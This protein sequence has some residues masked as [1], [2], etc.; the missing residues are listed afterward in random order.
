MQINLLCAVSKCVARDRGAQWNNGSEINRLCTIFSII[1][2]VWIFASF[3]VFWGGAPSVIMENFKKPRMP[4]T[5]QP[6]HFLLCAVGKCVAR[7]RGA[8]W[9]NGFEINL[10]CVVSKCVA[11]ARGAQ[12]NN[13][14][15]INRLCTIFK[16]NCCSLD[17]RVFHGFLPRSSVCNDGEF[18]KT[19]SAK[20]ATIRAF[21][22]WRSW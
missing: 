20:N 19:A 9:N 7:A 1:A 6:E 4:K 2:L 22:V 13:G 21:F 5:R 14:S 18:Q 8:Q 12:L 3:M 15:E 11:R 17:F 10:M 16:Y